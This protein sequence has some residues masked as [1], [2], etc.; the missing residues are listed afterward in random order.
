MP[1]V[2]DLFPHLSEWETPRL[3][4]RYTELAGDKTKRKSDDE[5]RELVCL[6]RIL[7]TRAS[8]ANTAPK[9]EKALAPTTD[10]L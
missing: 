6:S 4:A 8:T 7:R 10:M 2:M 3:H 5:L 1:D 9:R